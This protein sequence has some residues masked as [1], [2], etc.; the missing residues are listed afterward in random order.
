[1][2][3]V[4]GGPVGVSEGDVNFMWMMRYDIASRD[5]EPDCSTLFDRDLRFVRITQLVLTQSHC[6]AESY[7]TPIANLFPFSLN[8]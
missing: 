1:M 7:S 6:N 8:I 5:N 3:E 4:M 2:H